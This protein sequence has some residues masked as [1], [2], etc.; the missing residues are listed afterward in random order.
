MFT[1]L[2]LE[3]QTSTDYFL[4]TIEVSYDEFME[5]LNEILKDQQV[6]IMRFNELQKRAETENLKIAATHYARR[7]L[8]VSERMLTNMDKMDVAERMRDSVIFLMTGA[9]PS[10][11]YIGR[12]NKA[13]HERSK[14]D[15]K[16]IYS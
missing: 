12:R 8:E 2:E 1:S 9:T 14:E 6:E 3:K 10:L 4:N 15:L 7:S 11:V 13:Q 16:M 5:R